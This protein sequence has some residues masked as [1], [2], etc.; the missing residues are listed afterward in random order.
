MNDQ[1]FEFYLPDGATVD[2]H[3]ETAGGQPIN[4][5]VPQKEKEPLRLYFSV[6]PGQTHFR[7][8]ITCPTRAKLHWIEVALST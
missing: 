6:R 8:R 3:G 1:N 4:A 5:T 2:S 7:S